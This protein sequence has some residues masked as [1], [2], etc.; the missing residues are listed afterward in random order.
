M[1]MMMVVEASPIEATNPLCSSG[2]GSENEQTK[3]SVRG[4]REGVV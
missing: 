1:G 3:G 2:D 4:G